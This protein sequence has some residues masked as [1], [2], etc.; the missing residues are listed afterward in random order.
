MQLRQVDAWLTERGKSD[1]RALTVLNGIDGV[2]NVSALNVNLCSAEE[3]MVE[4]GLLV[5]QSAESGSESESGSD[6]DSE[7]E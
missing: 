1:R 4:Q 6:S 2:G 3:F 5:R 7:S